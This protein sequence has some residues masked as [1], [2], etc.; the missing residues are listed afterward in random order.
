MADS[1]VLIEIITTS[2]GLKIAAV[3]AAKLAKETEKIDKTQDKATKSGNKYHKLQKGVAQAGANSTKNFSKMNQTMGSGGSSGLVA[4]YATLAAN[5]FAATAAFSALSRAAEF[6]NLQT[7]L[8]ELG[9]TSGQTLSVVADGLREITG[10]ALSSEEAMRGAAL[11]ISGGFGGAELEGLAKIAK[12]A[13]ITLGRNLP[14]A[15]DRLTRG[16]IKLEPEILDELGIMVRVDDAMRDY[17][18]QLG[19]ASTALTQME[20]RQAFMNAIL[21]QGEMKFG[22]IA[23]SVETDVYAKLGA[24]FADL[25][26]HIFTFV[27]ESLRLGAVV[28]FL[29]E[30]MTVL[31]GVMILFGSTIASKM[32]PFLANAG[33]GAARTAKNLRGLADAAAGSLKSTK[34]AI[35]ASIVDADVGS[36][37]FKKTMADYVAGNAGVKELTIAKSKLAAGE[38]QLHKRRVFNS[39]KEKADHEARI[40][41]YQQEQIELGKLIA[42]ESEHGAAAVKADA[43]SIIADQA[44]ANS[45]AIAVYTQGGASLGQTL[46]D[47]KDGYGDL[48]DKLV[49]NAKGMEHGNKVTKKLRIGNAKL[50]AGMTQL[51]A[52]AKAIGA[53]FMSWLPLIGA[54]VI[55]AGV[56]YAIWNKLYNTKEHKAYVKQQEKL[57]EV[58][59]NQAKIADSYRKTNETIRRSAERQVQNFE[60]ISNSIKQVN[61]ELKETIRLRELS[62][63]D[64]SM[65]MS[66]ENAAERAENF[67]KTYTA[68]SGYASRA[69]LV[70]MTEAE[71]GA[72]MDS[73]IGKNAI[74]LTKEQLTQIFQV[75]DSDEWKTFQNALKSEIPMIAES[76]ARKFNNIMSEGI[77][78]PKELVIALAGGM[79]DMEDGM[80]GLGA[81]V[82]GM[83]TGLVEAEKEASKFMQSFAKTTKVDR[84]SYVRFNRSSFF[85]CYY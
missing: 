47:L 6:E 55:I 78:N 48:R 67:G 44:Q 37:A 57:N 12:G 54:I 83:H 42:L 18:V 45:R 71:V 64:Y 14:D 77:K 17:A 5:V 36:K 2:K 28:G 65:G 21:E 7:G 25:T 8:T 35:A 56:L 34:D 40:I 84:L 68:S 70:D 49:E 62:S 10:M 59:E 51:G 76:A 85:W 32:L 4:A 82:R 23:D 53:A 66:E 74:D 1:R 50:K 38:R 33:E 19:K 61:K 24:T 16:A 11:G 9:A 58:L 60:Q 73:L 27:N 29:A 39:A 3:D 80:G 26:K 81:A 63:K 15:F 46:G 69:V 43:A 22:H 75:K 41:A 79:Q 31:A 20:K 30:N 13:S 52:Q 72:K